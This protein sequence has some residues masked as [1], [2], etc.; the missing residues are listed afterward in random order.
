MDTRHT[1]TSATSLKIQGL[2][3]APRPTMEAE[4][5]DTSMRC[6]CSYHV[7]MSPLPTTGMF[8]SR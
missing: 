7:S 6:L 2:M 4:A 1:P 8:R 3:S 5:P